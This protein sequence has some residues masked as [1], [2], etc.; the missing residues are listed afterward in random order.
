MDL[1]FAPSQIESWPLDRLRPYGRK[2]KIHGTDQEAKITASM[3]NFG[4]TVPTPELPGAH[5]V[6]PLTPDFRGEHRAKPVP[7]EAYRP[8][9]DVDATFMERSSA[10]RSDNGNRM[11][12]NAARRMTSGG[13]VK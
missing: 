7:P 11:Y 6:H 5:P 8:V 12:I 13:V 3:A 9:A 10:F 4:W 2:A 1:D